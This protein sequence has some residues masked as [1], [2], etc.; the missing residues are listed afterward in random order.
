MFKD[1]VVAMDQGLFDKKGSQ[2][3]PVNSIY[4][5]FNSATIN[6]LKCARSRRF[7]IYGSRAQ[8]RVGPQAIYQQSSKEEAKQKEMYP[9]KTLKLARMENAKARVLLKLLPRVN[10]DSMDLTIEK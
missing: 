7:S 8:S 5:D 9:F 3:S 6:K 10:N 4:D 2:L 1:E